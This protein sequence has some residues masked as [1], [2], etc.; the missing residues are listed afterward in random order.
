MLGIFSLFVLT[1]QIVGG[2]ETISVQSKEVNYLHEN[3]QIL[4]PAIEDGGDIIEIAKLHI[5]ILKLFPK[6]SFTIHF[7]YF[8]STES[9][10]I[11]HK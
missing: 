7:G 8:F 5:Q 11:L 3:I 2:L 6:F 9:M 10:S 1:K 4:S